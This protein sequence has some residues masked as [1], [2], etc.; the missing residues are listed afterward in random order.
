MIQDARSHEIKIL[1]YTLVI[2]LKFLAMFAC[3]PVALTKI[4]SF[5]MLFCDQWQIVM[6]VSED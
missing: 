6:E 5:G 2:T 1:F 3:I 4:I